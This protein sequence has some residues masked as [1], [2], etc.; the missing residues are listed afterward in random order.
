[1]GRAPRVSPNGQNRKKIIII[2]AGI[3]GLS[4]GI[5][6]RRNGYDATIYEM[7]Y[8]PGGMCT[9]WRRRGFTFEG[10]MHYVGLVGASPAH[11]Y[12]RQWQELGV[13]PHTKIIHHDV[14]HTFRDR[15]GRTLNLYTDADRLEEE[16]LSLS[17]SDAE[18]IKALCTA[19]KRYAWLVRA[20]GRNPFRLV[21]KGAGILR[22]IPLLRKYGAM[23]LAE[24]AGRFSDPLIRHALTYLFVH[25]DFACT[26]LFFFLAGMHIRGSGF[27]QGSSLS[28][29]RTIER[30]FLELGG[31]IEYRRKVKRIEVKDGRATG[32][33]LDDG[34][35]VRA[36]IVISAADGHMTLFDMLEDRFTTPALR[37]RFATQPLYP[38]FVQVS[39]GV[40]RDLSG[41]PHA[42]KVQ[43]VV[44]FEIAGQTRQ[45]LWYQHFAFDPTMAP[46]GKTS[47]TVLYPSDLTW[48][49][50][51]GYASEAYKAEKER[52]L[53]ITVAQLEQV[54]P[55]I[56]SQIEASD[57][58]TPFTT[59][60]Y[61]NN[62]NAAQGFMLTKEIAAE[63]VMNPQ[64]TLPGLERFYMIGQWVKG[65]GTPM[66]AASGREVVRKICRADG[67]RF[68]AK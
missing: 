65:F 26:T 55:D 27:P 68:K 21:A 24:Y 3:A 8:L 48:W 53:E 25:P 36:D 5:Y 59:L 13:V 9:A 63:M 7:H 20:T 30:S 33:E 14:F 62:W 32:I 44:P 43:T 52:I 45:E 56:A 18:E 67:K 50:K 6:A 39:L 58:A 51:L 41:T 46:Q 11:G 47:V 54:L 28:L 29:A 42:V 38:S 10:C 57:V 4:A 61:T 60:R 17:P 35:A 1:M 19:V 22:A 12:Y 40:N 16:M 64:Y 49:E 2:G 31:K 66:A 37:E 23:N 34:T 15:S